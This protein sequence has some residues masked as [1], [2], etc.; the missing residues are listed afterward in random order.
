MH[1]PV[2]F[3]RSPDGKIVKTPKDANGKVIVDMK[4]TEDPLPT[5]RAMEKLV[6]SGKVK[7]IGVSN[8]NIRRLEHLLQGVSLCYV[9]VHY[10]R[11]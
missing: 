11:R 2:A 3:G 1:W 9:Q 7:S 10:E 6:E 5:W 8:F 4:L